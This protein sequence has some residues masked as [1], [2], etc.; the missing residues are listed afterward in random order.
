MY[1][2][3]H[4]LMPPLERIFN[5]VGADVQQWFAEMPKAKNVSW[6]TVLA[7]PSKRKKLVP[8]VE[9]R[10]ASPGRWDIEE[11][12]HSGQCLACGEPAFAGMVNAHRIS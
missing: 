10:L 8:D 9:D 12:F 7:S 5:L 2:I 6:E 1:Y 11:H 4:V 3:T